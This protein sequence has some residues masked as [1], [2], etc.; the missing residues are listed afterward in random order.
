MIIMALGIRGRIYTLVVLFALGS[1]GLAAALIWIQGERAIQ[2][3]EQSLQQ[4]VDNAISV[5]DAHR[6][7]AETGKITLD[8]AKS[9]AL[10]IINEL[11][12]GNGDYFF[13]RDGDGVTIVNPNSPANVGKKRDD[14][15]DENG[16][17]YV[18]DML[19]LA[20]SRGRDSSLTRPR[21]PALPVT[22]RRRP[23]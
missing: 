4:L 6:K 17:L 14:V 3:R 11:R 22:W 10:A 18:R 21:S 23:T 19:D 9:R 15:K 13:V 20:R 2:A 16:R 7:L 12:Y 8:E 5:L 1:S